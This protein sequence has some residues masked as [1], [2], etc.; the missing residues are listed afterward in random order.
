MLLL[1]SCFLSLSFIICV[2]CSESSAA[3]LFIFPLRSFYSA[4]LSVKEEMT[5][6]PVFFGEFQLGDHTSTRAVAVVATSSFSCLLGLLVCY[7]YFWH[8]QYRAYLRSL[9]NNLI[10]GSIV[11]QLVQGACRIVAAATLLSGGMKPWLCDALGGVDIFMNI[12]CIVLVL[13]FY[14]SLL[15]LRYNPLRTLLLACMPLTAA[16]AARRYMWFVL[17]AVAGAAV[18]VAGVVL[19]QRN[20]DEHPFSG[21]ESLFGTEHGYCS[22]PFSK[23]PGTDSFSQLLYI[24]DVSGPTTVMIV[25]SIASFFA[26]R[27]RVSN[28]KGMSF[29]QAVSVY[30]RFFSFVGYFLLLSVSQTVAYHTRLESFETIL[31]ISAVS[32]SLALG[33]LS[34]SFLVSERLL[35]RAVSHLLCGCRDLCDPDMS[36]EGCASRVHADGNND[37]WRSQQERVSSSMLS[38]TS[39]ADQSMITALVAAPPEAMSMKSYDSS[40]ND[41]SRRASSRR[42]ALNGFTSCIQSLL[43]LEVEGLQVVVTN[44]DLLLA[45]QDALLTH[46][47]RP[48]H[49]P[50]Q[51]FFV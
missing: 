4:P 44:Q 5:S 31:M 21:Q 23:N 47:R 3:F 38:R 9:Y 8:S 14:Y 2:L 36:V 10:V 29:D 37:V 48:A 26:L 46:G 45:E 7:V 15:A 12:G 39:S 41:V 25:L 18:V 30:I 49:A 22:I 16:D 6:S 40:L 35:F 1:L 50:R 24:L 13:G 19:L 33:V 34:L 42:Q 20:K 43:V 51:T 11:L 27:A 32:S 28:I 17:A